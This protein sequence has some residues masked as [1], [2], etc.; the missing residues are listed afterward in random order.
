MACLNLQNTYF[1]KHLL[2]AAFIRFRST[3]FSE[4]LKVDALFIKQP[5]YFLLGIFL[6]KES[7][8]KRT[9]I[10][11]SMRRGS[12]I[13]TFHYVFISTFYAVTRQKLYRPNKDF[14]Y[15]KATLSTLNIYIKRIYIESSF[16]F[17]IRITKLQYS[18]QKL[19]RE[20]Y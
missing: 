11:T 3:C 7:S 10:L 16:G 6:F 15:F 17:F 5:R 9:L 12:S 13:I 19:L 20:I 2:M 14:D 4:D 8:K 18:K 1:R